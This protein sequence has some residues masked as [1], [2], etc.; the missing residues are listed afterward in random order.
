MSSGDV[1]LDFSTVADAQSLLGELA[2]TGD[3]PA[4]SRVISQVSRIASSDNC[5]TH[6]LTEVIL[7][8]V[9]LTNKLLRVVNSVYFSQFGDRNINTVSRAIIILGFNSVRDAALSLTFFE[10]MRN[11]AQGS[12]LKVEAVESFFCGMIGRNLALRDGAPGAEEVM[13]CALFRNLGRLVCRLHSYDRAQEVDRLIGETG[14]DEAEAS[15]RV[16]G[17]SYDEISQSLGRLWNL[18]DSLLRGMAPLPP[19]AL[20]AGGGTGRVQIL[21]NLAHDIYR[22][23]R[24]EPAESLSQATRDLGKSYGSVTGLRAETL[25]EVVQAALESM[26]QEA[27]ILDVDLRVS[28]TLRNM[29]AQRQARQ[30]GEEPPSP[31]SIPARGGETA[32]AAGGPEEDPEATAV[33]ISGLQDVTSLLLEEA[34]PADL[35]HVAAELL[36]RA[37]CFDTVV[38]CTLDAEGRELLG[39]VGFGAH[40]ERTRLSLRIP[41]AFAADVFHAAVSKN[42][43]LLI[44][45]SRAESIRKRIPPWYA[46]RIGARSFL[47]LPMAVAG[48]TVAVIYGDRRDA[49]LRL[50]SATM[51]LIK[52]L[53]NQLVLA[54]RQHSVQ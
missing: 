47:L 3:F 41:T 46:E 39:H 22:V 48:R 10:H 38:I 15:T 29:L 6:D 1:A 18:P 50:P 21:A 25:A 17:L 54:L 31:A 30:R 43:D 26:E 45:D 16:F 7:H 27:K 12:D 2:Q 37:R 8:D 44:A 5:R 51:A 33:L 53:R 40:A 9:A 19:G 4:L 13:I 20:K 34:S 52:S 24:S 35:L 32:P 36:Y 23:V 49:S 28:P 14:I 42:A 11:H